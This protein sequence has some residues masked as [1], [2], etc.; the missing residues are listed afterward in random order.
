MLA[1]T[2]MLVEVASAAVPVLDAPER[3]GRRPEVGAGLRRLRDRLDEAVSAAEEVAASLDDRVAGRP[4]AAER[5]AAAVRA[6]AAALTEAGRLLGGFAPDLAEAGDDVRTRVATLVG[7]GLTA[8]DALVQVVESGLLPLG[9]TP[10]ELD[11]IAWRSRGPDTTSRASRQS[12]MVA[13]GRGR[14]RGDALPVNGEWDAGQRAGAARYLRER[15]PLRGLAESR[16]ALAAMRADL[17]ARFPA[18]AAVD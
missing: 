18:E 16:A 1:F 9:P 2:M 3:A 12:R 10:E 14:W 17:D 5:G 6:Q 13:G 15:R 11:A 4:G 8:L 7:S